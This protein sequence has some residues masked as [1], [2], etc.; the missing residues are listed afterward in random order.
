M[1][2][3]RSIEI[4]LDASEP[5]SPTATVTHRKVGGSG[6]KTPLDYVVTIGVVLALSLGLGLLLFDTSDDMPLLLLIL[7][8]GTL[9]FVVGVPLAGVTRTLRHRFARKVT[10]QL[11]LDPGSMRGQPQ[12]HY[13]DETIEVSSVEAVAL[14]G[15]Q[16]EVATD[17]LWDVTLITKGRS[18]D[19][20]HGYYRDIEPRELAKALATA[21]HVE[22]RES[23]V[24]GGSLKPEKLSRPGTHL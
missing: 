24:A 2:V 13:G 4:K 15:W 9:A 3:L 20:V 6:G 10:E 21:L 7:A 16:E 5:D 19:I 8:S 12:L 17:R 22:M 18:V 23:S 11:R 14:L 1:T